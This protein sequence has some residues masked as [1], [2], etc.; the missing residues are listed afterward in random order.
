MI[1]LKKYHSRRQQKSPLL[2]RKG[3]VCYASRNAGNRYHFFF[4]SLLIRFRR[5]QCSLNNIAFL[6]G[7]IDEIIIITGYKG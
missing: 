5:Y 4:R 6:I 2:G 3:V 1:L 7:V